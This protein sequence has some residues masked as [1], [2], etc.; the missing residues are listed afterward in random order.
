MYVIRLH[1]TFNYDLNFNTKTQPQL[2][3]TFDLPDLLSKKTSPISYPITA[4]KLKPHSAVRASDGSRNRNRASECS[5]GTGT[6]LVVLPAQT[7]M[8]G[9][10]GSDGLSREARSGV[11]SSCCMRHPG[12]MVWS[13]AVRCGAVRCDLGVGWAK[14]ET[15]KGKRGGVG[16]GL[17]GVWV[18]E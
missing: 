8:R 10:V 7:A 6:P 12:G 1:P 11:A 14:R 5:L 17:V 4:R 2:A 3:L 16:G 13:S 9:S 18:G 15:E